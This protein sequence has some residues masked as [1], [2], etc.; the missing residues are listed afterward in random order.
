MLRG[1]LVALVLS[2]LLVLVLASERIPRVRA[3]RAWPVLREIL[4]VLAV[5]VAAQCAAQWFT[6]VSEIRP[7]RFLPALAASSA[8]ALPAAIATGR[9]RRIVAGVSIVVIGFLGLA[10][11]LYFRF[12]GG[13]VPLVSASNAKQ[14]WNVTGSIVALFMQRDL[15]FLGLMAAGGWLLATRPER[16]IATSER[17]RKLTFRGALAVSLAGVLYL[18]LDVRGWLQDERSSTAIFSWKR[19]LFQTGLFGG[20]VRDVAR[21]MRQ[22]RRAGEPLSAE[23]MRALG[24]YLETTRVSSDDLFGAARGKNLIVVQV[25]A[26]QAWVIDAKVR[27]VEITPFLN[28]LSRERAIYFNGIWDQTMISPT[29]DSEFLSMNSLHPLP[30]AA[31]VFRFSDNDFV[32]LPGL[33]GRQGYSTLSVHAFERGFWNRATIHPRYGFQHSYFDREL[34]EGPK[35]GWGLPDKILFPRALEQMDRARRPFMAFVI[36]LTSHHPYYFIPPEEQ[37]IET[38]GLPGVL[39]GYVASMR[40]VDEALSEFFTALSR[41]DYAK[42]TIVAIYGDHESRIELDDTA[43]NQARSLLSLDAQTLRDVADRN[44]ATRKV[45]FLVVLPD[46][47]QG[48]TIDAVGGQIDI[49]PTLLHLTG[50]SKPKSMIGRPLFAG[51]GAVFRA[52]G[53]AVEGD[54]LRLPDGNCRTLGGKGLPLA[55]CAGLGKRADEQLKASWTITDHNLAEQLSDE[56]RASR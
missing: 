47:K 21:M 27:G 8:L 6:A 12:F 4:P 14:A 10:D 2:A 29:A 22:T 42:D 38:R 3:H 32:A 54:R 41:R 55:E 25:E 19:W 49:A 31:V 18:G 7:P 9:A 56:L 11:A 20:H 5:V 30:D 39:D 23:S 37:H 45:P 51:G 48:R 26:L 40:Y 16:P 34:G 44:F 17:L 28:R 52:D 46:A 1:E 24:K 50:L 13:I 36:T 15:A 53:S 35:V 43:E 33:L